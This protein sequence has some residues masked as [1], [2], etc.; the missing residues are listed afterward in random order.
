MARDMLGNTD[1]RPY[2]GAIV[3][4]NPLAAASEYL[5]IEVSLD[6]ICLLPYQLYKNGR[7]ASSGLWRIEGMIAEE[8]LRSGRIPRGHHYWRIR[9]RLKL[10]KTS[11]FRLPASGRKELARKQAH[12]HPSSMSSEWDCLRPTSKWPALET[13][14]SGL[15]PTTARLFDERDFD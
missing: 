10:R 4:R 12:G 6:I 3:T 8:G 11:G 14:W 13:A 7:R 1:P 9:T 2:L 15:E 5:I